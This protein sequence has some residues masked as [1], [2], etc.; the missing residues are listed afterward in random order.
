M[1]KV[2]Q[3]RNP[4]L[5]MALNEDISKTSIK[6][7]E[8]DLTLMIDLLEHVSDTT[9]TLREVKRI[10]K[11]IILKVPLE[12]NFIL[13]FWDFLKR[14][15]HKQ[16]NIEVLGHINFYNANQL[17]QQIEKHTGSI[18]TFHYANVFEYF[19]NSKDYQQTMG[20]LH[21]IINFMALQ[22]YKI[23]PKLNAIIFYDF[24]MILVKCY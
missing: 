7:K 8:I 13:K 2:Q 1:L 16:E 12:D 5:K 24:A 17:K 18:S 11:F 23:S 9:K 14:G 20:K 15:K 21:K 3:K 19:Q 22:T 10:S 6:D 4:D